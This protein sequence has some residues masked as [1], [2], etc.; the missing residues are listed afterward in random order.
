MH[1]V[2]VAAMTPPE[3]LQKLKAAHLELQSCLAE[4]EALTMGLAVSRRVYSSARFRISNASFR[5]RATFNVVCD[6]LSQVATA[7]EASVICQLR[8]ADL[9][10]VKR[11]AQHVREW[12]AERIEAD[13]RQYCKAS[14]SIRS[15]MAQELRSVEQHLFPILSSQSVKHSRSMPRAA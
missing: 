5:R 1:T 10:L 2:D 7:E 6:K 3:L 13:W 12:S 4:M 11:S 14:R 8:E 15:A 9:A